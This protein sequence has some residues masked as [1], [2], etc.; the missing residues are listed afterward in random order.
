M[1][2]SRYRGPHR[3]RGVVKTGEVRQEI[4]TSPQQTLVP[5]QALQLTL[6]VGVLFFVLARREVQYRGLVPELGRPISRFGVDIGYRLQ[7][8]LGIFQVP[9]LGDP[10]SGVRNE[11][12]Q[13]PL[14][15]RDRKPW[16]PGREAP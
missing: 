9:E 15:H 7:S 5:T 14:L 2:R 11:G 3:H 12:R 8:H 6:I 16:R 1:T 13:S 10:V 4:T